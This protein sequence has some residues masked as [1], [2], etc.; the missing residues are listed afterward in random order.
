MECLAYAVRHC[1]CKKI[2]SL[3][4]EFFKSEKLSYV[5]LL[6]EKLTFAKT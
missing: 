1:H 5:L 3:L 2:I 6:V 4:Y